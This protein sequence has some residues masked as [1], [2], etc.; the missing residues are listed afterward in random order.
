MKQFCQTLTIRWAALLWRR[1]GK[2]VKKKKKKNDGSKRTILASMEMSACFRSN[3]PPAG[4]SQL[5]TGCQQWQ[6][7]WLL[8][9][10]CS[11]TVGSKGNQP[12]QNWSPAMRQ[13][14]AHVISSWVP[15]FFV[16]G[17]GLACLCVSGL[18]CACVCVLLTDAEARPSPARSIGDPG[19]TPLSP[20]HTQVS[21]L[22]SIGHFSPCARTSV[23]FKSIP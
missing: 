6:L 22:V 21:S 5:C 15:P 11:S 16:A 2:A 7:G 8:W 10:H 3:H 12:R 9:L 1:S 17:F 4:N 19:I 18:A 20:S 14:V 13:D 23:K